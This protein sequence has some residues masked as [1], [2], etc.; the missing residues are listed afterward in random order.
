MSSTEIV[1]ALK[2][3][4]KGGLNYS[5]LKPANLLQNL[6]ESESLF[7]SPNHAHLVVKLS[8]DVVATPP[9]VH[10]S[11]SLSPLPPRDKE[12][13]EHGYYLHDKE[14]QDGSPALMYAYDKDEQD[15]SPTLL[16]QD[17]E[18]WEKSLEE[19]FEEEKNVSAIQKRHEFVEKRKQITEGNSKL[20]ED[21]LERKKKLRDDEI[22]KRTASEKDR[23][24][25]IEMDYYSLRQQYAQIAS[26]MQQ[27][28]QMCEQE[29]LE[30]QERMQRKAIEKCTLL[31]QNALY[32][33]QAFISICQQAKYPHMLPA[34]VLS[35]FERSLKTTLASLDSEIISGNPDSKRVQVED[36]QGT[37]EALCRD[38][39]G[40]QGVVDD[41]NQRGEERRQEEEQLAQQ[42]AARKAEEQAKMAAQEQAR[43]QEEEN[44]KREQEHRAAAAAALQKEVILT[45]QKT[46]LVPGISTA[47]MPKSAVGEYKTLQSHLLETSKSL[48]PFVS[49]ASSKKYRF[50]LQKAVTLHVNA[51]SAQSGQQVLDKLVYLRRLL[52]KQSVE[53]S[54]RKVST[55]DHPLATLFCCNLLAKKFVEQGQVAPKHDIFPYAAV[56]AAL[57]IEFPEFGT[58]FLAHLY[59]ACPILV[60]YYVSKETGMSEMDHMVILG[61]KVSDDGKAESE[62][63]FLKRM[64]GVVRLY[65]A[66]IQTQVA[67][68]GAGVSHPHGLERGWMWLARVL[69]TDPHPSITATALGEFLE[70]CGYVLQKEYKKQFKK[71]FI[72]MCKDYVP[73][74]EVI[75]SQ[76][77]PL[78]RLKHF[79]ESCERSGKVP[80]P[81]GLLK[82][83][84][85]KSK[86]LGG[87][88]VAA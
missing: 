7:L 86:S 84:F 37:F 71:L 51:I 34:E 81:E 50:D 60:P 1:E 48:Q 74:I 63:D 32:M 22:A 52:R 44:A 29:K 43:R 23:Q 16:S 15:G 59:Q 88:I 18:N 77:G 40:L 39:S 6:S 35:Q 13:P 4:P 66:I 85:W 5:P 73:K 33:H 83:D 30:H 70:V 76:R 2:R 54:G 21:I 64:S 19:S 3:T 25:K 38:L 62:D 26:E 46:P 72:V 9:L 56:I 47:G 75:T 65:A 49:D 57:W 28:L 69:N 61:Y 45:A 79:L 36:L 42:E 27:K 24:W 11:V 78:E 31:K 80:E 68:F 14:E 67:I 8:S 10:S 41:C 82:I 58:L 55:N 53:V 20:L 87:G 12:E 17:I